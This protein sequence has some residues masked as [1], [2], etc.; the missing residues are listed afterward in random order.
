MAATVVIPSDLSAAREAEGELLE[1]VAKYGYSDSSVFAI[2]LAV[3]EAINNAIKH[4]NKFDASKLVH[5]TYD[6]GPEQVSV[7]IA[8]EGGGFD[9]GVLPDPTADENI[10]KPTGRG[11][12]LMRAYMDEVRFN[13]KGNRVHLIKKNT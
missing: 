2:K 9:P 3:E 1:E 13:E 8:D 6:V 7:T 10:E 4:G 11:V 5:I 12:M